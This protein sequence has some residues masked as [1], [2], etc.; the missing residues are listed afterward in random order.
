MNYMMKLG[1]VIEP[2]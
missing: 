1:C 2:K